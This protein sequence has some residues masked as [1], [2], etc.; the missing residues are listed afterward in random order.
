MLDPK[1]IK[2]ARALLNWTQGELAKHSGLSLP[3]IANIERGTAQPRQDTLQKLQRTF[4]TGGVEF[5]DP[6]G[7][8]LAAERFHIRIWSGREGPLKLWQDLIH[9]FSDNKG[10]DVLFS[11]VNE[12]EWVGRYGAELAPYL[13]KMST[14]GARYRL[15]LCE[16]DNAVIGSPVHYRQVSPQIFAQTPYCVYRNKLALILLKRSQKVTLIENAAV[17]ETFRLQFESNWKGGTLIKKPEFLTLPKKRP[18]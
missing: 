17:A 5:L 14:L 3:A 7:V 15:L 9:E 8:Q 6:P 1:L 18:R 12:R 4:E 16:G 11:G 10:G 2:A 13:D